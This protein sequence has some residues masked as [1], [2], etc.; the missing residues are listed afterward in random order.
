MRLSLLPALVTGLLS[1]TLAGAQAT[2]SIDEGPF[3][4][5]LNGS[6]FTYQWPVNLFKFKS[7]LQDLEMAFMDVPPKDGSRDATAAKHRDSKTA[8]LL[9]GKNFCAPTWV[10]TIHAL[11]AAG[12]RV[13]APDQIGFCKSS[14]PADYQ[15]SLHQLSWNTRGLL[16]TL[17]IEKATVIGHSMGG[18][19]SARFG[20]LYPDFVERLVSVNA[21][22]LE[23]YITKGVPYIGIEESVAQEAASNYTSIRAYQ[24]EMYYVG[25]WEP[26]YDVWVNMSNNIYHGSQ[27]ESFIRAQARIVDMVL[28]NPVAPHF[29]ALEP[30]TLLMIGEKDK[31]AIG[32]QWSPPE[33]AE[34][35]GHFDEL[36]PEVLGEL[37]N[38]ELITFPELGHA[39]Q[40]SHSKEFH[41]KLIQWLTT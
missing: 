1:V 8:V 10:D 22:G 3:P 23:D 12:Y 6:N 2:G 32:A 7:Q 19:L 41:E 14:K 13:I 21:I 17:G 40:I 33:V 9:H 24:Q 36:G 30:R 29:K 27:R 11:T 15:Y 20:L 37:P 25:E 26:V 38:G 34:K 4:E 35:L 5:D 18:M 31:T 39:P 28:T 16:D